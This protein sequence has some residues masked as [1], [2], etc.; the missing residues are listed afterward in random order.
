MKKIFLITLVFATLFSC[1]KD[2]FPYYGYAQ[3]EN[4]GRLNIVES[5]AGSLAIDIKSDI[6]DGSV[7]ANEGSE[8]C[9]GAYSN[10][11]ATLNFTANTGDT[12]RE[13]SVVVRVGYHNV[14]VR[15]YQR[16]TGINHIEIENPAGD[17][18]WTATCSSEQ[19]GDGGG[20]TSIFTYIQ[21]TFWH[22]A[23]SPMASL[24]HWIVVDLKEEKQVNMV[25]LGWRQYGAAFYV[26]TKRTEIQYSNDGLNFTPTGGVIIR[27]NTEG[28]LSSAKYT[29]YSDCTFNTVKARYIRLYITES[30]TSNGTCN[31][32]YFKAYMP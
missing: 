4:E 29:P 21:T 31:V 17:M 26:S 9:T 2:D 11:V 12:G 32:A 10:G 20:V 13:G 15:I 24:P 28:S 25:R 18:K 22:S 23:Y 27:E 3:Y 14:P 16:S 5:N 8:W 30:N 1:K 6:R 7:V 19:T